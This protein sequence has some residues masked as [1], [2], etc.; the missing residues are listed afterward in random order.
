MGRAAEIV[1]ASQD[2][3]HRLDE[4]TTANAD[5]WSAAKTCRN[6]GP[7]PG[8]WS[9]QHAPTDATN[10]DRTAPRKPRITNRNHDAT[11]PSSPKAHVRPG[12]RDGA[13]IEKLSNLEVM[14]RPRSRITEGLAGEVRRPPD[15]S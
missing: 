6:A 11:T 7:A 14:L 8:Q 5:G 10:P 9:T 3:P 13:E 4:A 1:G 2:F 15:C 12:R